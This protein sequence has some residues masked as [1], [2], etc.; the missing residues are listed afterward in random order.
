MVSAEATNRLLS[1]VGSLPPLRVGRP[2]GSRPAGFL[3]KSM[4][5]PWEDPCWERVN[6]CGENPCKFISKNPLV[7]NS[8]W[9]IH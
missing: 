4:G 9:K 3:V 6:L 8:I 5:N 7:K 1:A 2:T